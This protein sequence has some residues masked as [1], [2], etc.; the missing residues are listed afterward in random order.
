MRNVFSSSALGLA[1]EYIS[2][3]QNGLHSY[4][5]SQS[6]HP[7]AT[8]RVCGCGV[9][10]GLDAILYLS[11]H[12]DCTCPFAAGE[13][14]Q[15]IPLRLRQASGAKQFFQPPR[16]PAEADT[17]TGQTGPYKNIAFYFIT[18]ECPI[19]KQIVNFFQ[20][21]AF[22][23]SVVGK[24]PDR[25]AAY[26][27]FSLLKRKRKRLRNRGVLPGSQKADRVALRAQKDAAR[28]G[29]SGRLPTGKKR[30]DRIQM[31]LFQPFSSGTT[32]CQT[33]YA[34]ADRGMERRQRSA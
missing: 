12:S 7:D 10:A 16:H 28:Q 29:K 15:S 1:H 6:A 4:G 20:P 31:R 24:K 21:F 33:E 9:I 25:T 30:S 5:G 3:E 14:G 27:V 2:T 18:V 22:F 8:M 19:Y 32:V 23:F 17:V 26:A 34:P 13:D 11:R